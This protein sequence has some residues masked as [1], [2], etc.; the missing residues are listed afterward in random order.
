MARGGGLSIM[1]IIYGDDTEMNYDPLVRALLTN[2]P[3]Q[4]WFW[5][6]LEDKPIILTKNK[7]LN[8]KV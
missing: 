5:A 1:N 4:A 8:F 2:R 3:V 6:V 7:Y